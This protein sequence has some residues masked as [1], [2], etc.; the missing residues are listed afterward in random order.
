[1][2]SEI[3]IDPTHALDAASTDRAVSRLPQI[4]DAIRQAKYALQ[5]A[6]VAVA[7][8]ARHIDFDRAD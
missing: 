4:H 6:S 2:T 1:M 8:V 7:D 5:V 3:V